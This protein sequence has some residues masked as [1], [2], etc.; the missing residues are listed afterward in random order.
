MV[1]V[2]VEKGDKSKVWVGVKVMD[3]RNGYYSVGVNVGV[4]VFEEG[5]YIVYRG[6]VDVSVEFGLGGVIVEVNVDVMVY[7]YGDDDVGCIDVVKGC[8]GGG[9]GIGFGGVKV[10]LEVGVDVVDINCKFLDNQGMDV[11]IG[12]FVD[13]G[14]EVGLDGVFVSVLGFGFKVGC[15]IGISIFFGGLSFKFW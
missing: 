3:Y 4:V 6:R 1:K 8:V 15:N 13:I 12:L 14:F 9:F 7:S 5:D 10:K 2:Y 11:N